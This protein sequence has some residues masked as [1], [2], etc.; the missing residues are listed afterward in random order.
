M[1][2]VKRGSSTLDDAVSGCDQV[3]EPLEKGIL[4]RHLGNAHEEV[5][6]LGDNISNDLGRNLANFIFL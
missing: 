6:K 2:G 1:A 4:G 5:L 3:R